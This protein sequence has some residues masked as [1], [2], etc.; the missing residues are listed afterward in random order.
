M[1]PGR[2]TGSLCRC[3]CAVCGATEFAG[4][5]AAGKYRCITCKTKG[6]R[7]KL[8]PADPTG[9]SLARA[10][11]NRAVSIGYLKRASECLCV[12]CGV[13]AV[14]YDH[15]DYAKPL[16]VEPV[17]ASCNLK[18]GPAKPD[19]RI[20]EAALKADPTLYVSPRLLRRYSVVEK[21]RRLVLS[22]DEFEV[23]R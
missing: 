18:R 11:V 15:R 8:I 17:C 7:G 22:L 10:E 21:L 9:A 4:G 20:F 12:D 14:C 6:E 16:R 2:K 5:S 3:T 1:K 19:L 23:A 13:P